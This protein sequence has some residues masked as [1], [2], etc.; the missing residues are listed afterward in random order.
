MPLIYDNQR[1]RYRVVSWEEYDAIN[2]PRGPSWSNS[3]PFEWDR[4]WMNR[5]NSP[6]NPGVTSAAY[7]L[8]WLG[9]P[10]FDPYYPGVREWARGEGP[11]IVLSPERSG[12]RVT[13]EGPEIRIWR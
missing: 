9:R 6:G 13:V 4:Y 5:R 7:G 11:E 12:G 10:Y 1:R 8:D 3:S 2:A